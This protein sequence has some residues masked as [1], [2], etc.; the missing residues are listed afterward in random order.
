MSEEL[1]DPSKTDKSRHEYQTALQDLTAAFAVWVSAKEEQF[2]QLL[3][4]G[5]SGECEGASSALVDLE[6]ETER[7]DSAAETIRCE[8]ESTAAAMESVDYDE[9]FRTIEVEWQKLYSDGVPS[10][11]W[12][13]IADIPF[14]DN[15]VMMAAAKRKWQ[16][17]GVPTVKPVSSL[18]AV[19]PSRTSEV[20]EPQLI[21]DATAFL[22]AYAPAR[23]E[24]RRT[25]GS[26][27][28]VS[29]DGDRIAI[30]LGDWTIEAPARGNWPGVAV[31][32]AAF[33]HTWLSASASAPTLLFTVSGGFLRLNR[34]RIS[35]VWQ[36]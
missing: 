31:V 13:I 25:K 19:P 9:E 2:E 7:L 15:F 21:V 11:Q 23:R 32:P 28:R 29:Y 22:A 8:I 27:A 17:A 18:P 30:E 35:C 3:K 24:S 12:P 36:P 1:R 14:G 26:K 4:F 6:Q 20:V 33:I 16:A 5:W 34:G 10:D